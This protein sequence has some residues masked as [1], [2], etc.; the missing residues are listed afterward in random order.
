VRA[1]RNF[2]AALSAEGVVHKGQLN[3]VMVDVT[4]THSHGPGGAHSHLRHALPSM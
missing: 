2:A 1:V 4:R 3:V